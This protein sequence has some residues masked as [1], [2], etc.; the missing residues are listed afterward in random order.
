VMIIPG[1]NRSGG[2]ESL[3]LECCEG[4]FPAQAVCIENF[5]ECLNAGNLPEKDIHKFKLRALIAATHPS[6][7]SLGINAWLSSNTCPFP[8]THRALNAV[9]T[10]ISE[11]IAA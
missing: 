4:L 11:F 2:L 7:P 10:F 1:E 3:I 8:L 5:C 9:A 6:D